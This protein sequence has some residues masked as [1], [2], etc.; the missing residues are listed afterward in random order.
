[1]K[2]HGL[3]LAGSEVRAFLRSESPKTV[4]RRPMTWRNSEFGSSSRLFWDHANFEQAW[5]D[6]KGSS[7][8]EYLHVPCH[9]GD[10]AELVRLDKVWGD[11]GQPNSYREHYPDCS[12]CEVCDYQGW[13]MTS[14]RLWCRVAGGHGI[15]GR[16]TFQEN[17]PPSG[18]IYKADD[19]ARH[20]DSG[21][22]SSARMPRT[23]S[24]LMFDVLSVKAERLQDITE[25]DAIREGMVFTEHPS[26]R[27]GTM[28]VDGGK[29]FHPYATPEPGWSAEP[30]TP[31]NRCLTTARFAFAN[32]WNRTRGKAAPWESNPLVWRY[33]LRLARR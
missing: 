33:E 1:M 13:P 15:R 11:R 3:T 14:H 9:R 26:R 19:I 18:W 17:E 16:E 8:E 25:E 24:R 7:N 10:E 2:E 31:P 30:G 28:S 21:W 29:S 27:S 12:P 4:L 23:A 32:L 6:G 5:V 20:I 22:L